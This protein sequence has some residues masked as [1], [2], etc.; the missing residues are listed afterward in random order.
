V[1]SLGT[2]I[3]LVNR[4]PYPELRD[5]Y[6]MDIEVNEHALLSIPTAAMPGKRIRALRLARGID[7]KA[8]AKAAGIKPPSLS[9]LESGK[10]K[11]LKGST[12]LGIATALKANPVWINTGKG[13]PFLTTISDPEEQE[14]VNIYRAI[15]PEGKVAFIAMARGLYTAATGPSVVAAPHKKVTEAK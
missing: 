14:I 15:A 6:G 13:D 2:P 5:I 1:R 7:Q 11:K 9:Q 12:L 4:H 10:S 8:L 3:R